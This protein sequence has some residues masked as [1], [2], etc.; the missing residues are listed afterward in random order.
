MPLG[1]KAREI[2]VGDLFAPGRHMAMPLYQRSYSWGEDEALE[3]L[4]D[5]LDAFNSELGYFLGAVVFVQSPNGGPEEIVDGQQ[6]LTT[7]TMMFACLR[8]LEPDKQRSEQIHNLIA[9]HLEP[10]DA[11]SQKMSWRLSLNH[12][13]ESF[14]RQT[15]QIPGATRTPHDEETSGSQGRIVA[16]TS[17]LLKKLRPMS[18]NERRDFV[19]WLVSSVAFVRVVVAD[20]TEG[21]KVFRV[22]N[23]RGKK[24]ST[25]DIIKSDLF[26]KAGFSLEEAD[27]QSR[28]W[29]DHEARLGGQTFDDLLRQIRVI[30]D[31]TQKGDVLTGFRKAIIARLDIGNFLTETLPLYVQAQSEIRIGKVV[32]DEHADI[33]NDRFN[34]MRALDHKTWL[35]PAL[36]FLVTHRM[37]GGKCGDP[38]A[39]FI[40]LER[41][42]Y[43]MQIL[44]V[45]RVPR[46][47][48]YRKLMDAIDNGKW[49]YPGDMIKFDGGISFTNFMNNSPFLLSRDECRKIRQNLKHRTTTFSKRR[50]LALRLN[51]C[52]DGGR[53]VAPE[54]DAT[55]EHVFPRKPEAESRWMT[56]WP[57]PRDRQDLP[58]TIGN[59]TLLPHA[60]NQLADRL[61]FDEKKELYD[62]HGEG[63]DFALT[64][65][66]IL[67]DL[68]TPDTVKRRTERLIDILCNDWGIP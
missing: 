14:F 51:A 53:T 60:L 47:R 39:F 31:R 61:D 40:N 23:T 4:S 20:R 37:T 19:D 16:S 2:S 38:L 27:V 26:E 43:A 6:R 11:K 35:A 50:A 64:E 15:V 33:V 8:D 62:N 68:W 52:I 56:R 17:V 65:D 67:E 18:D 41:L 21:Y 13:D 7:L 5:L 32:L 46:N 29:T 24:P 63:A 28:L 10:D 34:R 25:H 42:A 55:V 49:T 30:Y 45:E 58:D 3:L 22:L 59:F 54:E 1:V 12:P 44:G 66:I 9:D 36:K 57:N 48:R